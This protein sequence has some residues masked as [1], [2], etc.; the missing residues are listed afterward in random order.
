[1]QLISIMIHVFKNMKNYDE[2]AKMLLELTH[3]THKLMTIMMTWNAL[4]QT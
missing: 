4:D 2:N 1:M 3:Q